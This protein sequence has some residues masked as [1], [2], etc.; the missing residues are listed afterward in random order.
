MGVQQLR[1]QLAQSEKNQQETKATVIAL[2]NEFMHLVEIWSDAGGAKYQA[3]D[4]STVIKDLDTKFSSLVPGA[5]QLRH[6]TAC[7]VDKYSSSYSA[8]LT[9]SARP[10]SQPPMV[11]GMR[12]PT[13]SPRPYRSP[14]T[15]VTPGT[16]R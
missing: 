4:L 12:R 8:D 5:S 7:E 6:R 13:G 15:F 11:A 3:S 9:K 14:G 10:G 16:A 2:R 1:Q